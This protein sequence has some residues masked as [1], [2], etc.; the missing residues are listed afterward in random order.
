MGDSLIITDWEQL[1]RYQF[2]FFSLTL[3]FLLWLNHIS[4]VF[5]F[6]LFYRTECCSYFHTTCIFW[7]RLERIKT[8][9]SK[10]FQTQDG[11]KD[12]L[13]SGNIRETDSDISAVDT[14][15]F[16][17]IY[18]YELNIGAMEYSG[19]QLR[20]NSDHFHKLLYG[21]NSHKPPIKD[22]TV[23][24]S[25][26]CL[27][28]KQKDPVGHLGTEVCLSLVSYRQDSIL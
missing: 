22:L 3:F 4:E 18:P 9:R 19:T 24:H 27:V 25:P 8:L 16:S 13:R 12:S 6:P 21:L 15:A 10:Y 11:E 17:W 7:H 14:E 20:E 28:W 26:H 23:L 5:V 2:Y 1:F